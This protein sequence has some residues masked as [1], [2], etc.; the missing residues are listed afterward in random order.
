RSEL[1]PGRTE[2][3]IPMETSLDELV[4]VGR[5]FGLPL[6]TEVGQPQ[7]VAALAEQVD[8]L[9]VGARNMQNVELLTA[10]GRMDRPVLLKRGSSASIDDLLE[11]ANHVRSAGNQQVVLCEHGIRTF[12]TATPATLDLA[13]VPIL[14]ER[15]DLPVVVAPSRSAGD[16]SV[17]VPLALAAAAAGADGLIIECSVEARSPHQLGPDDLQRLTAGLHPILASRGRRLA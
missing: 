5:Q 1:H 8:V 4:A 2:G 7:D 6:V 9:L 14:K 3:M 10:L 13:A 11:A 17:V 15:T 16:R 12:E